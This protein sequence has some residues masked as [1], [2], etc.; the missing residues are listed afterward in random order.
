MGQISSQSGVQQGDP[1]GPLLFSLVLHKIAS[2]VDSDNECLN[3]L[4][5]AWFLDD[6]VI[7]GRKSDVQRAL[8]LID[9]LGSTLGIYINLPKYDLISQNDTSSFPAS[10]KSCHLPNMDILGPTM[11][12][13]QS[14]LCPGRA[15]FS[16]LDIKRATDCC[17]EFI[18]IKL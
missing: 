1:L 3:L 14:G 16:Q 10:M 13:R 15:T 5:Q 8:S 6:G 9:E 17:S 11:M 7:A 12:H 4:F 18:I 2:A